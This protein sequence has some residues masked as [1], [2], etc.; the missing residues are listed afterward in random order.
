MQNNKQIIF[1]H[2]KSAFVPFVPV[3]TGRVIGS[4]EE[5]EAVLRDFRSVVNELIATN[6]FG[7]MQ[8]LAHRAGLK[9]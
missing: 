6:Y 9:V 2:K 3:L 4:A 1:F 7:T 8:R 5:S